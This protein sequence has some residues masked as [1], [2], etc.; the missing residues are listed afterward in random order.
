MAAR[1]IALICFLA[2][3]IIRSVSPG[4]ACVF[5][6]LVLAVGILA[7]LFFANRIAAEPSV[8]TKVAHS[9]DQL[10]AIAAQEPMRIDATPDWTRQALTRLSDVKESAAT[11]ESIA[12]GVER[13]LATKSSGCTF[14]KT[15]GGAVNKEITPAWTATKNALDTLLS[16]T[17]ERIKHRTDE[18]AALGW[19]GWRG[20]R[21]EQISELWVLAHAIE[22]TTAEAGLAFHRLNDNTTA[23]NK[24]SFTC[25]SP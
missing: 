7:V 13:Q 16:E 22:A 21:E 17:K 15:D 2:D 11:A 18:N 20:S 1:A 25:S 19:V 4:I 10:K 23:L 6:L 14:A 24:M 8:E 9:V 3:R 12:R 5:S